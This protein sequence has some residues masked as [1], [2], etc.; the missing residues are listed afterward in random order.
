MIYP[1][2]FT[3]LQNSVYPL[4]SDLSYKIYWSRMAE[5]EPF[6]IVMSKLI[7]GEYEVKS[8]KGKSSPELP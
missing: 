2:A 1:K 7:C 8:L 4:S 3:L 5:H 6:Q